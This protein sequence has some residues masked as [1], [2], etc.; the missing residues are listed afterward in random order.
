[1]RDSKEEGEKR[2]KEEEMTLFC[3]SSLRKAQK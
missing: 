2:R 1:M 3:A